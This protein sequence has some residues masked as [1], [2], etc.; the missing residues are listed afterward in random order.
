MVPL[1]RYS[2]V[3]CRVAR[4]IFLVWGSL[5]KP[6]TNLKPS[7]GRGSQVGQQPQAVSPAPAAAVKPAREAPREPG[8]AG[9]DWQAVQPQLRSQG[10]QLRTPA[11]HPPDMFMATNQNNLSKLW[12]T[13]TISC[14]YVKPHTH[15]PVRWVTR[16]IVSVGKELRRA[17]S[18]CR[19]SR[20]WA[21]LHMQAV[22]VCVHTKP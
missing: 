5:P 13:L 1:A 14:E 4:I 18:S 12:V 11:T 10:L 9:Q 20:G 3:S 16:M 22:A 7:C 15:P 19:R 8:P 2:P 17:A 21:W 6:A